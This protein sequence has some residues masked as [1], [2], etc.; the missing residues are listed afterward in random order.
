MRHGT[1]DSRLSDKTVT[2]SS[3]FVY[4]LKPFQGSPEIL[5]TQSCA[6]QE[7]CIRCIQIRAPAGGGVAVVCRGGRGRGFWASVLALCLA[8]AWAAPATAGAGG[9]AGTAHPGAGKHGGRFPSS[10]TGAVS[11]NGSRS[12]GATAPRRT[13]SWFWRPMAIGNAPRRCCV[14]PWRPIVRTWWLRSRL[15]RPRPPMRCWTVRKFPW[16]SESLPIRSVPG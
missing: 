1:A 3:V 15:S 6:K 4:I 9:G 13:I 14:A 5:P 12:M 7:P 10:P 11:W 2:I 16:F 8:V